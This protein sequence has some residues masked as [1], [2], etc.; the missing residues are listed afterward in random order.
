[1]R[2]IVLVGLAAVLIG[3]AGGSGPPSASRLPPA[4]PAGTVEEL[5]RMLRPHE[6][7]DEEPHFWA[8]DV[9]SLCTGAR[10]EVDEPRGVAVYAA[11][12][13]TDPPIQVR[14]MRLADATAARELAHAAGREAK[15]CEGPA[16]EEYGAMMEGDVGVE[17]YTRGGWEGVQVVAETLAKR[18]AAWIYKPRTEGHVVASKGPWVA[19]AWWKVRGAVGWP[20]PHWTTGGLQQVEWALTHAGA[21]EAPTW[22]SRV[23]PDPVSYGTR[24]RVR[25]RGDE[26]TD[27]ACAHLYS[28]TSVVS[29]MQSVDRS[30]LGEAAVQESVHVA[31]DEA[32]AERIRRGKMHSESDRVLDGR[33]RE[34][35][36][37]W[38][39][40]SLEGAVGVPV[41]LEAFGH[42]RWTGEIER[43]A[44]RV[45]RMPDEPTSRD[46]YAHVAVSVR[47]GTTVV[48]LQWQVAAGNDLEGAL[49]RG[50]RVLRRALDHMSTVVPK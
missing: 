32:Q 25:P 16:V 27:L 45:R 23:L 11:R 43:F 12:L 9:F 28:R 42:G 47:S 5:A 4:E 2:K 29:S 44:A 24:M 1:M 19:H 39:D 22:L 49:R 26:D 20:M 37:H 33:L 18:P 13:R 35:C 38:D 34:P 31:S 50:E 41:T 36:R 8:Y 10:R 7:P 48:Y 17:P 40:Q 21:D 3:A 14:F 15:A 30:M 6:A 46:S